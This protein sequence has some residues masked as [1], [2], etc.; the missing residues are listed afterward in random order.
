M[1][2]ERFPIVQLARPDD[3][4]EIF[5]FPPPL[6]E[7]PVNVSPVA[8]VFQTRVELRGKFAQFEH[9]LAEVGG[10]DSRKCSTGEFEGDRG[11]VRERHSEGQPTENP[12]SPVTEIQ[13]LGVP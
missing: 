13:K 3:E 12:V 1:R 2:F 9:E 8:P 11:H 10:S 7:K 4:P 6:L 5:T